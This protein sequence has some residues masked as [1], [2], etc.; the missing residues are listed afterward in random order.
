MGFHFRNAAGDYHSIDI[1]FQ[2]KTALYF[3][4]EPGFTVYTEYCDWK[5]GN[6]RSIKTWPF[7]RSLGLSTSA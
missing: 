1:R 6:L 3:V 5:S 7:I 2:D 4:I